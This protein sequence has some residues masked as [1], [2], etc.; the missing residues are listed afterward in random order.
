MK[1][2]RQVGILLVVC[3]CGASQEPA[4]APEAPTDETA[5]PTRRDRPKF[6]AESEIGALDPAETRAAFAKALPT[7]MQCVLDRRA[8]LPQL[9]GDVTLEARIDPSGRLRR[10]AVKRSTLG[11]EVTESCMIQS[12]QRLRWPRPQGGDGLAE[13]EFS[14]DPMPD[15]RPAVALGAD[16]AAAELARLRKA[17]DACDCPSG[18][19]I[20]WYIHP[21]GQV[22]A[23]GAGL[24]SPTDSDAGPCIVEAVR[25]IAWPTPGSYIGKLSIRY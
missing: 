3:S 7:L 16:Y 1:T 21:D 17:L 15:V 2:L 10:A 14:F 6:T 20:A 22:V 13:N 9:A 4:A 11:D 5:G 19:T 8:T 25:G 18:S 23:A 12:L 24:N